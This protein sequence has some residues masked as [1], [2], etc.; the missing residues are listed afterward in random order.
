MATVMATTTMD[1]KPEQELNVSD[2][3]SSS[4]TDLPQ[5]VSDAG[6]R[7]AFLASFKP[8]DDKAIM[9]KVDRRFLLLIGIL[10]RKLDGFDFLEPFETCADP[11]TLRSA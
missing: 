2:L 9:K 5:S 4:S 3:A 1:E 7:E 6:S 10:Y 11:Y 8:E